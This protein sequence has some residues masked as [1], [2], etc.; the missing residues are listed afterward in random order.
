M[1]QY[2][3][4]GIVQEISISKNRELNAEN[5]SDL[6]TKLHQEVNLNKYI[7]LEDERSYS[8]T[9]KDE[10]LEQNIAIYIEDQFNIYG[11][12]AKYKT[13]LSK[14][15]AIKSGK[16]IKA[17][18][19]RKE[20]YNFHSTIC[21]GYIHI[22]SLYDPI[23]IQYGLICF[24]SEGKIIMECYDGILGYLSKIIQSQ[25]DKYPIADCVRVM[26]TG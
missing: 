1:G 3:S 20:E 18:A 19:T 15:A 7:F 17:Y 23:M 24:I 22:E 25:Q 14:L 26:I 10:Y 16:E 21:L 9:I 6:T 8:W 4:I 5:L 11:L 12:A 13:F 2:L